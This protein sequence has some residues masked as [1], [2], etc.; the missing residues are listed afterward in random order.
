M[1]YKSYV[2]IKPCRALAISG[3]E[4]AIWILD[5]SFGCPLDTRVPLDTGALQ[6]NGYPVIIK[7][8]PTVLNRP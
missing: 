5:T 2:L 6:L 3:K 8:L 1:A 4:I 7:S